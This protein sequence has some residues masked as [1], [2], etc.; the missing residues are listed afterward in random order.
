MIFEIVVKLQEGKSVFH[1]FPYICFKLEDVIPTI[2][3]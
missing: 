1:G 2:V 3:A